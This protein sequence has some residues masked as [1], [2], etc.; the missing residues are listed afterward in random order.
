[1]PGSKCRPILS[2]QHSNKY[3][4]WLSMTWFTWFA[5]NQSEGSH[6]QTLL[7]VL[8]GSKVKNLFNSPNPRAVLPG[9]LTPCT[10]Y[11]RYTY[12]LYNVYSWTCAL[13]SKF[14]SK[15]VCMFRDFCLSMNFLTAVPKWTKFSTHV[16][17]D[18]TY[19][20]GLFF[21]PE[22]GLVRFIHCIEI[23]VVFLFIKILCL[24][25]PHFPHM[26]MSTKPT[27]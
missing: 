4:F 25:E 7:T 22:P 8:Q 23:F 14:V 17:V 1:L 10:A 20:I 26:Y 2:Q 6:E 24:N 13:V 27:R 19:K 9:F 5:W 18:Q 11:S 12:L 3:W 15:F 21:L 16:H